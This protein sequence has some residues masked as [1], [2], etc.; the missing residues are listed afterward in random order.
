[1]TNGLVYRNRLLIY[2]LIEKI[3][4]AHKYYSI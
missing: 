3:N 1:M 4:V 2:K